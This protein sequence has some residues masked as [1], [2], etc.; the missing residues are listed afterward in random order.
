MMLNAKNFHGKKEVFMKKILYMVLACLFTVTACQH[1]LGSEVETKV[2]FTA[3]NEPG[4]R[5][6]L[7]NISVLWQS[8]DAIKVFTNNGQS[9]V[10]T[11]KPFAANTCAKFEVSIPSSDV[12]YAVYPHSADASFTGGVIKI[13]VPQVQSGKFADVNFTV[14]KSTPE[15]EL[16]FKH[17]VGYVEFTIDKPGVVEI[18]G[19]AGDIIAG[20]ICVTDFDAYV[21]IYNVQNGKTSVKV[22]VKASGTYYIA[23]LPEAKLETLNVT[24][25]DGT[26]VSTAFSPNSMI[27]KRGK[28]Y[29]LGNITNR[30]IPEGQFGAVIE[31]FVIEEFPYNF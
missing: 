8:A 2:T 5:T 30:L 9:A 17:V 14:A 31:D 18:F 1:E 24:L 3:K 27:M 11:A 6:V 23:L 12:Y 26:A 13:N 7:N 10:A 20:D 29:S 22:E 28:L 15:N 4:L 16:N 21:P 19:A 25:T